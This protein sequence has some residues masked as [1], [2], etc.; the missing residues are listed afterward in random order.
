MTPERY[1]KRILKAQLF[2]EEHLDEDLKLETVAEVSNIS[3][4]H[5]H[6]IFKGISGETLAAYVRRVR[7]ENAAILLRHAESPIIEIALGAGYQTHESFTRAFQ[8]LPFRDQPQSD[9]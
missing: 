4:F 2:I 1:D 7:L 8:L 5:F 6:R 3:P 9:A